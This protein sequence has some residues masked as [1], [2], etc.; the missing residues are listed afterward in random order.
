M[1]RYVFWIV[2][3]P[4]LLHILRSNVEYKVLCQIQFLMVGTFKFSSETL[5]N[6]PY[7]LANL[8]W[9]TNSC[10]SSYVISTLSGLDLLTDTSLADL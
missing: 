10:A 2:R 7:S 5:A 9:R 8:A 3:L 4:N 6:S 1:K